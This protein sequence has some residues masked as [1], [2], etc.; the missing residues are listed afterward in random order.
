MARWCQ[1]SGYL[2]SYGASLP[3]HCNTKLYCSVT[4]TGVHERLVKFRT[5]RRSWWDSNPW[6]FSHKSHALRPG[7]QATLTLEITLMK[8]DWWS[9]ICYSITRGIPEQVIYTDLFH[10]LFWPKGSKVVFCW[11][12]SICWPAVRVHTVQYFCQSIV[13][14]DVRYL[15]VYDMTGRSVF[16]AEV[17]GTTSSQFC[18]LKY[19]Y[20]SNHAADHSAEKNQWHYGTLQIFVNFGDFVH[21]C[22]LWRRMLPM[23][24]VMMMMCF[25]GWQRGSVVGTSV[26]GWQTFSDLCRIYSWHVTTS[27]VRCPLCVNQPGQLNSVITWITWVETI[28]RQT[29]VACGWSVVGQSVIAGLAYGLYA[30]RPLSVTWTAPLQLRYAACGAI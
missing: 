29:R 23:M 3:L 11:Y 19:W 17:F 30:V 4:E 8:N 14:S 9:P 18:W 24:M 16:V 10:M 15:M 7:Y 25:V 22:C 27:W 2:P 20:H 6:P 13:S 28:K 26:P 1:T 5:R 12:H 21:S